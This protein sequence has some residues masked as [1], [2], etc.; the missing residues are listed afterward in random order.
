MDSERL[1][2]E[3]KLGTRGRQN[4][5]NIECLRL[6]DRNMTERVDLVQKQLL[7]LNDSL[8][9]QYDKSKQ[10]Q[11][12][13]LD[14]YEANQ[15]KIINEIDE[16]SKK[17][18]KNQKD[19]FENRKEINSLISKARIAEDVMKK[20]EGWLHK[21]Q[22]QANKLEFKKL[23]QKDF[24][25]HRTRVDIELDIQREVSENHENHFAMVENFV[26]KFVPIRIQ[27]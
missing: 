17:A 10:W 15:T 16:T 7:V 20:H 12:N 18:L 1:V 6:D 11:Q 13:F 2:E 5:E 22:E 3:G 8:K 27:S 9:G 23:N 24:E 14:K 21:V 19:I 4:G 26:E 25:K